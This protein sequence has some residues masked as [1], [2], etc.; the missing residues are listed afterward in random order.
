M[1]PDDDVWG[2][3]GLVVPYGYTDGD[4]ERAGLRASRIRG[5]IERSEP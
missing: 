4:G 1:L 5:N 2:N 3:L